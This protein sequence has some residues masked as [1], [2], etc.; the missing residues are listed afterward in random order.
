MIPI[1]DELSKAVAVICK[2]IIHVG[3]DNHLVVRKSVE[4]ASDETSNRGSSAV[5]TDQVARGEFDFASFGL[6]HCGNRI[7]V[8][9]DGGDLVVKDNFYV[10]VF[11]Q[12]LDDDGGNDMLSAMSADDRV[13]FVL[14]TLDLADDFVLVGDPADIVRFTESGITTLLRD[15][16]T[17]EFIDGGGSVCHGPRRLHNFMAC[18]DDGDFDALLGDHQGDDKPYRA[19]TN[20]D[21]VRVHSVGHDS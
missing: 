4:S 14:R 5:G 13:E 21:N 12:V 17:F 20:N 1:D 3:S 2:G 7:A 6:T 19:S 8:I 15:P 18:L 10:R 16:G 11:L 9:F